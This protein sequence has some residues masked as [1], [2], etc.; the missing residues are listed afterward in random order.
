MINRTREYESIRAVFYALVIC[1]LLLVCAGCEKSADTEDQKTEFEIDKDYQRGPLTVHIRVDKAEMTI[2]ETILLEFEAAI[3]PGFEV[4]M[5]GV[6]SVLENFGIV[7]W[8][9]LGDKLDESNNVVSRYQY[10]L[11]PFLSG[12]FALPAFT[13]QFYDVNSPEE[14]TYELTTEPIDIEVTSL[15]GEQRAELKIADIEGVVEMPAKASY[16]WVWTLCAAGVIAAVSV[17][18]YLRQKRVTELVRY[19]ASAHEIAYERLR[20]LVKEDMVKKGKIKEFYEQISDILRRYIEHRF[21]LRAPERTTEE[22]LV[23]L[24]AAEVLGVTDKADLGEFLEHC[25]LVKFA[26]HNPTTEQ[27]QKTFDL[28]KNF[29]EKTKSDEKKID[30]T[31]SNLEK[32][33]EVGSV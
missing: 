15:L 33:V 31:D 5:P 14:N 23:E 6:D 21:N 27:I 18:L 4:G 11:E 30:V 25:D 13:F 3:E 24:A 2:A 12:T 1:V 32:V 9:N 17:W 19:S 28:V 20:A 10:R 7:D 29:I 8:D 22:F 26:K 16:W